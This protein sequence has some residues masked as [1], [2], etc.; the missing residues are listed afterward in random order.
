MKESHNY[1]F[2]ITLILAFLLNITIAL[3]QTNIDSLENILK[4]DLLN[5]NTLEVRL[6]LS[7]Y[8]LR[9]DL[10]KAFKYASIAE[11]DA[12]QLDS[13]RGIALALTYQAISSMDMGKTE[14]AEI[15]I[16]K[17][18]DIFENT[19]SENTDNN[20]AVSYSIKGHLENNKNHLDKA[21]A[22]YLKA[23]KLC[24]NSEDI[25]AKTLLQ[26]IIIIL[27]YYIGVKRILKKVFS[28]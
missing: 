21:F 28:T 16:I 20:L 10:N 14:Q 3:T 18:I 12:R 8:Y 23:A 19:T 5:S 7:S 24:E 17:A 1:Q 11:K 9:R 6:D 4:T 13:Q 27:L 22:L 26:F 15:L 2:I 25:N